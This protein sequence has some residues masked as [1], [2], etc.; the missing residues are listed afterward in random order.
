MILTDKFYLSKLFYFVFHRVDGIH[1][2]SV[3]NESYY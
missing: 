3:D 2:G 1:Q